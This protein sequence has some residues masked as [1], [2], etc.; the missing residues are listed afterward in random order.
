MVG[1]RTEAGPTAAEA[2]TRMGAALMEAAG[3]IVRAAAEEGI[4]APAGR[5]AVARISAA[6]A[7]MEDSGRIRRRPIVGISVDGAVG[8]RRIRR[9]DVT[10]VGRLFGGGVWR[11]K[12]WA[13]WRG[14]QWRINGAGR[15]GYG[16]GA[17]ETPRTGTL[18]ATVDRLMAET[19]DLTAAAR[20]KADRTAMH[21]ATTPR[22][23]RVTDAAVVTAR[24]AN[25]G[26]SGDD[27]VARFERGELRRGF[28]GL[29][30]HGWLWPKRRERRIRFESPTER[31][32]EFRRQNDSGNFG[33]RVQSPDIVGCKS[34]SLGRERRQSARRR[35]D[36]DSELCSGDARRAL[37]LGAAGVQRA[38]SEGFQS[39]RP[40]SARTMPERSG[41]A[42]AQELGIEV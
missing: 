5:V 38:V 25:R 21:T 6:A 34:G 27:R 29:D 10:P 11:R 26:N 31:A 22:R 24:T 41:A 42:A 33:A 4:S 1:A 20:D 14:L 2:G 12:L 40:P 39:D 15:S 3:R 7:A 18:A 9:R 35:A 28:G 16:G 19:A 17:T 37:R 30:A 13:L 8:W 36:D 32:A 23:V